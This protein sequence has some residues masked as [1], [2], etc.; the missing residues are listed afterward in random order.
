MK[1]L[2]SDRQKVS[3]T[4]TFKRLVEFRLRQGCRVSSISRMTARASMKIKRFTSLALSSFLLI[5]GLSISSEKA[6]AQA[7]EVTCA[8]ALADAFSVIEND[9]NVNVVDLRSYELAG[10]YRN[11]PRETPHA[12]LYVLEGRARKIF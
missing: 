12:V 6:S 2:S 7:S 11:Y 8:I 5:S 4:S 1:E 9:R 10:T 3:A